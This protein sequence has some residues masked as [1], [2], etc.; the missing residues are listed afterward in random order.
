MDLVQKMAQNIQTQLGWEHTYDWTQNE[1]A[2][3]IETLEGIGIKEYE[4]VLNSDVV[5]IILPGGKGCHT[6]MGIALGSQ[7]HIVLFDPDRILNN[8]EEAT[9]FYFLPQVKQWNGHIDDLEETI[10]CKSY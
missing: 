3:T 6:E 9:T 2:E 1:K 8:L 4:G 10:T 5:I 7:K